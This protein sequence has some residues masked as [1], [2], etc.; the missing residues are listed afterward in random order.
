MKNTFKISKGIFPIAVF[1]LAIIFVGCKEDEV[2]P[3]PTAGFD[4][5]VSDLEVTFTN[6]STAQGEVTYA[7]D[8]GDG[9]ETS[10]DASPTYTY[11]S[12]GT[13]EV[14][15][16]ATNAGGSDVFT[17]QVTVAAPA[18]SEYI[19]NGDFEDG[20]TG[21]TIVNHYEAENTLGS[22]TIANGVALWEETSS[23]DW[24]HMGIYQ[25]ITLTPGTYQFKMDMAYADI[26]DVWGEVY[27]GSGEPVNGSDYG[28]DQGATLVL[29]AYNAWDCGDIKT[30]TGAATDSGC[31]AEANPGQFVITE[32]GTYYI[33]FRSGGGTYGTAGIEIDNISVKTVE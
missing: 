33:L 3:A 16:T 26:N 25:A 24:K 22:V 23:T 1:L 10:A 27:I 13:Y 15:L 11:T 4:F 31:D 17:E 6:T 5:A 8:F 9:S 20:E 19:T 12:G 2:V 14:K 21:W 29:K 32:S 18:P 7:W 28:A 30:Y